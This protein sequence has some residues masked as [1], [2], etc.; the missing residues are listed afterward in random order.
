MQPVP[1]VHLVAPRTASSITMPTP[2]QLPHRS[3]S[4]PHQHQHQPR[5]QPPSSPLPTKSCYDVLPPARTDPSHETTLVVQQLLHTLRE[6]LVQS[7]QRL[8]P[9]AAAATTNIDIRPR[10][11]SVSQPGPSKTTHQAAND[12][13]ETL[14][15]LERAW[16]T[17][18]EA[19]ELLR[20]SAWG[21]SVSVD[22]NGHGRGHHGGGDVGI[23]EQLQAVTQREQDV[24]IGTV[25][26]EVRPTARPV[27]DSRGSFHASSLEVV[28]TSSVE[29]RD[30]GDV[31]QCSSD[32]GSAVMT[33]RS[34]VTGSNPFEG[35]DARRPATSRLPQVSS[36]L[37]TRSQ[38]NGAAR[39]EGLLCGTELQQQGQGPGPSARRWARLRWQEAEET[40]LGR[41]L[42]WDGVEAS[43][44][45]Y[46]GLRPGLG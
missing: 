18:F 14:A 13:A 36:G 34:E 46:R 38:E 33:R 24:A 17:A 41:R 27:I 9:D 40:R 44:D 21:L 31:Q 10:S 22:G 37:G 6:D 3:A 29:S 5:P 4:I 19:S 35:S 2:S 26:E 7:L 16:N 8:W 23:S 43:E 30:R 11:S 45:V 25:A 15:A 39:Q 28:G 12:N 42:L 32:V 20:T 1:P